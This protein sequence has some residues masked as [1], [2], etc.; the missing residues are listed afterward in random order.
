MRMK[1]ILHVNNVGNVEINRKKN[2]NHFIRSTVFAI[3][4]KQ[5]LIL[6]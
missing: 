1:D 5:L 6:C 3:K 2:I 4:S